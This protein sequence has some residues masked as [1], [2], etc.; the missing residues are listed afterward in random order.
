MRFF[1]DDLT[2]ETPVEWYFLPSDAKWCGLP[3]IFN[4]RN[5]YGGVDDWPDLGEIEGA[6]RPYS[7]GGGAP[8]GTKGPY[9]TADQWEF[10]AYVS[11]ALKEGPCP[12][13]GPFVIKVPFPELGGVCTQ[14]SFPSPPVVYPLQQKDENTWWFQD[15]FI[16]PDAYKIIR[17]P[18]PACGYPSAGQWGICGPPPDL[19]G[20]SP[21]PQF[22]VGNCETYTFTSIVLGSTYIPN[23]LP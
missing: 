21:L 2:V 14:Q 10:G 7:K 11:D 9:G 13:Q 17:E 8:V 18:G 6:P 3:N 16:V 15:P 23:P 4:S 19:L 12:G 20:F 5:W 1:R 22:V